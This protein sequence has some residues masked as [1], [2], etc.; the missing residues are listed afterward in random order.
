MATVAAA[1]FQK[2]FGKYRDIAQREAVAV[3]SYGRDSVVLI[4]ATD[5]ERF[6]ALDDRQ[7]HYVWE[8]SDADIER[9]ATTEPSKEAEAFNDEYSPS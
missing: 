5:Y 8:M 4:S 3:T 9:L 2:N 1:E 6:R 7:T